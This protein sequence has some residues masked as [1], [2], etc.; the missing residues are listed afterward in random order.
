M[1]RMFGTDG[2]RG[3]AN[4]PPVSPEVIMALGQTVVQVL[5]TPAAEQKPVFIIGRD[6]R[7]S[8]PMLEAAMTAGL[9]A[10]GADV[11]LAG[12]VPTPAVAYLTR[13][14][15]A[16]GGIVISA[17]HNP[18]IDNGI[19]IFEGTGA[20][21]AD[22]LEALIESQLEST[23][24]TKRLT[25]AALGQPILYTEGAQ[26]YIT[27]LKQLY[28]SRTQ[29]TL[30]VG[31][32]CAHGAAS[33]IAPALFTQLGVHVYAWNVAP[34]GCNI[35]QQCGAVYPAFMQQKVLTHN[36]D[37][38][39]TFDGDADR[40]L[41]VDHTGSLLDG[42]YILAICAQHL[43]QRVSSAPRTIVST[44][45]A[46]IGLEQSLHLLGYSLHRTSVGDKYVMQGMQ[47]TGA[48]L[49]GEQSGHIVFREH[50]TTGDGLLTA[51][52]LL[53]IMGDQQLPLAE[54]KKVLQKFPQYILNVSI[55]ERHDPLSFVSVQKAVEN[56]SHTL[57]ADGR[58]V[59]RLSGTENV[60]R[61]MV[62]GPELPVVEA[63]AQ[64]LGH[65]IA[66]E[67]GT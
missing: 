58:I 50:H 64:H 55:R 24:V 10:A 48:I 36:L 46:N 9:C 67:L 40:L 56:A 39:F 44:I 54:L 35:N 15:G 3:I 23:A 8:S 42:D 43:S 59:V 57:G 61:V 6:T 60:V 25:G 13:H 62:E 16:I 11:L 14:S 5:K 20:K 27:F 49:G 41:A 7:L 63:L 1:G 47:Q 22:A 31:L 21:L 30:R 12:I 51:I 32:D 17:S 38:G 4:V 34:D 53:N 52:Q 29:S 19:K 18:Y 66:Q 33:L 37:V 28:C 45:M 2:I 26:H 65:A